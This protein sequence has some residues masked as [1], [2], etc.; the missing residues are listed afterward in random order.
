MSIH[1]A[2]ATGAAMEPRER[3]TAEAGRGIAGD[4][5]H[6]GAGFYSYHRGPLREISL[7]EAETLE[8]LARDHEL[9]VAPGATRR[10]IV[11][12]GVPLNHLVD[13][14]FRAGGAILRGVK[15]CEP[16]KHLVDVTGQRGLLPNL[17]H[18]GGLHAQ[19]VADNEIRVGDPVTMEI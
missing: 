10:N 19:I 4:R 17:I 2:A 18:R 5:Y 9:V 14:E 13:R 8:A 1:V 12:R 3:V 7:I 16:C 11:T 15:L 6:A